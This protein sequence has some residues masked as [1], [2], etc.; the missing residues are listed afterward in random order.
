MASHI[1]ERKREFPPHTKIHER[2]ELIKSIINRL[3]FF[4]EGL[5]FDYHI[6]KPDTLSG[7]QIEMY[8]NHHGEKKAFCSVSYIAPNNIH[9][10][11]AHVI[12]VQ[13]SLGYYTGVFLLYLQLLLCYSAN[14]REVTLDNYT[15]DPSRAAS[16]IYKRFIVNERG[17]SRSEFIG[18]SMA[19]KLHA[20]EGE[21]RLS[22]TSD[23]LECIKIDLLSI[24]EKASVSSDENPW[25]TEYAKRLD[26]FLR[27]MNNTLHTFL[28]ALVLLEKRTHENNRLVKDD[29]QNDTLES[30]LVLIV[31]RC[32]NALYIFRTNRKNH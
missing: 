30:E 15:N 23:L 18:K 1:G 4:K 10:D 28:V 11:H 21:M 8:M 32:S 12:F 29:I 20:S 14:I 7:L 16:G 25:N 17:H 5:H 6:H 13:S 22:M 19:E 27:C 26:S 24:S 9:L 31:V 3:Q 2:C